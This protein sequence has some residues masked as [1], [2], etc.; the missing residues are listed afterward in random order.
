[1]SP[2][3]LGNLNRHIDISCVQSTHTKADIDNMISYSKKYQFVTVFAMPCYTPYVI[4]RLQ[5]EPQINV[6][7]VIGFPTGCDS[8]LSKV[9]QAKEMVKAGCKEL[10]MVMAYG[11]LKSKDYNYVLEDIC[12]VVSVSN[13][14]PVK[15][16]IEA[17]YLEDYEISKAC[18]LA[19]QGGA[20]FVKSGTGWAPNPTTTRMIKL[21]KSAVGDR[22]LIKAAGGIR[23]LDTILEMADL[24]C[25]RFGISVAT[26]VK[27]MNEVKGC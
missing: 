5:E 11:L 19:I 7:G 4:S 21:M 15:V 14:L 9:L 22:V 1:M 24:G 10:D 12:S 27:I 3:F 20:A 17:S 18:E 2:D 6:G 26:A 25:E 23:S 13:G 16:I 8:T